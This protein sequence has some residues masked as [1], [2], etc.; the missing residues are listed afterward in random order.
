MACDAIPRMQTPEHPEEKS[1]AKPARGPQQDPANP[2][3]QLG[4]QVLDQQGH[5]MGTV[6]TLEAGEDQTI[7]FFG[8]EADGNTFYLPTD[9]TFINVDDRQI[10]IEASQ[11]MLQRAPHCQADEPFDAQKQRQ[12]IDYFASQGFRFGKQAALA[13]PGNHLAQRPAEQKVHHAESPAPDTR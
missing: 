9:W 12:V 5:L 7:S 1:D 2:E 10:R 3:S 4:Y 6:T 8:Y 13:Y 11:K